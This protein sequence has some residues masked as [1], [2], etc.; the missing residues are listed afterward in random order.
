[1][2]AL[3]TLKRRRIERH[4]EL[5]E[6]PVAALVRAESVTLVAMQRRLFDAGLIASAAAVG[7]ALNKIGWEGVR[8]L[9]AERIKSI[10]KKCHASPSGKHKL[11]NN[12][13]CE[14]CGQDLGQNWSG[15]NE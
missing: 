15:R 5:A 9:E 7:E 10:P 13:W 3:A 4:Q 12:W 8:L 14:H 11:F 6:T 1:M 2:S